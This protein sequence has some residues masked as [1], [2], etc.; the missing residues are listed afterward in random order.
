MAVCFS[1][2]HKRKPLGKRAHFRRIARHG[3]R[4]FY[5]AIIDSVGKAH[6]FLNTK[7]PTKDG[8][9]LDMGGQ[10]LAEPH[11]AICEA[12]CGAAV[13]ELMRRHASGVPTNRCAECQQEEIA[14][15]AARIEE[16]CGEALTWRAVPMER[17]SALMG[18]DDRFAMHGVRR[19]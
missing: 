4:I 11:T 15:D 3:S 2:S 7:V 12:G 8:I 17:R 6:P 14:L 1:S 19:R 18:D 13:S 9:P 16:E 5:T 10:P